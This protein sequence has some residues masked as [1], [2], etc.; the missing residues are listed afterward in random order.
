MQPSSGEKDKSPSAKSPKLRRVFIY[1]GVEQSAGAQTDTPTVF[2]DVLEAASEAGGRRKPRKAKQNAVVRMSK[3]RTTVPQISHPPTPSVSIEPA[4]EE[5]H[6][7]VLDQDEPERDVTLPNDTTVDNQD[8]QQVVQHH[9]QVVREEVVGEEGDGNGE[10]NAGSENAQDDDGDAGIAN[11]H[12]R[13][14]QRGL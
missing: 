10:H 3:T 7:E 14:F 12:R 8:D 9:G 1:T 11:R 6:D 13:T 2:D 4:V 5:Q